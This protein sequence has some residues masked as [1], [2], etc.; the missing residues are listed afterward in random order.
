MPDGLKLNVAIETVIRSK[1]SLKMFLIIF[2]IS[3]HNL[4]I[5]QNTLSLCANMCEG[6]QFLR[7]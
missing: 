4:S 5:L 6:T 2:E 3:P 1:F 7:E